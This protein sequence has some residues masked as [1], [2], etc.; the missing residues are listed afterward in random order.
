MEHVLL[1]FVRGKTHRVMSR[2]VRLAA[3]LAAL[4]LLAYPRGSK[5]GFG[6]T[7]LFSRN[8]PLDQ[9]STTGSN[10]VRGAHTVRGVRRNVRI[11]SPD[12]VKTAASWAT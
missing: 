8:Q 2:L 12:L 3:D 5:I 7:Q 10:V 11:Y 6:N 4:H 1:A 9:G